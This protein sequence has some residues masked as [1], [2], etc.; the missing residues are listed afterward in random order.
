MAAVI[1]PVLLPASPF[2]NTPRYGLFSVV[3]PRDL[4]SDKA[5]AGG[6]EYQT[7]IAVLPSGYTVACPTPAGKTLTDQLNL[8]IS[9][10]FV[11]IA[12]TLC[13][14]LGHSEAEWN[15]FVLERLYAGEQAIVENMFSLG[16]NQMAPSLANNTPNVTTLA[17]V[18]TISAGIDAL[19]AW[20]YARYGPRGV[21]HIPISANS[22]VYSDYHILR[23]TDG[24]LYTPMGTQVV[25]G[26]YAGSGPDGTVPASGHTTFYITGQMAIWRAATPFVSP[27]GASIDKVTNQL[28]MYAEREYVLT[29]ETFCAGVDVTIAGEP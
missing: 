2:P 27:Y 21:L 8:D 19:E 23:D 24:I 7:A 28:K 17:A 14:T 4:P 1:P 11:V 6:I 12:D 16:L 5:G 9:T 18:T 22:A 13:G 10:P 29:Y 3:P 15:E 25:F 20:L 26:N